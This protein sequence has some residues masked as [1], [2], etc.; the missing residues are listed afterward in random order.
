MP[1]TACL[2]LALALSLPTGLSAQ[3]NASPICASVERHARRLAATLVTFSERRDGSDSAVDRSKERVKGTHSQRARA[4]VQAAA[5]GNGV[6]AQSRMS[7]DQLLAGHGVAAS[8]EAL[9]PLVGSGYEVVVTDDAGRSRRGRVVSLS[10]DQ[11]VMASPVVA[12]VWEALLPLYFP[13]DVGVVLKRQLFRSDERRFA[14]GSIERIDIVDSTRNGTAFGAA[15]GGGVVGGV[16]LWER[17]QPDSSLKGLAT[18]LALVV[19]LPVSLRVGHVLDRA[20]NEPIYMR[21]PRRLQLTAS[22][23][24]DENVKGVVAQLRF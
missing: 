24:L 20:I 23:W 14:E 11:L 18:F 1:R 19:G 6:P 12:G 4:V 13:L 16:Y 15:V 17:R 8:F 22:P 9:H 5:A 2:A 7:A 3:Q 21:Q 10:R